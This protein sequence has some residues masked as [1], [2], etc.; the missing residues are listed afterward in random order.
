MSIV[1]P[2]NDDNIHTG[3]KATTDAIRIKEA[4]SQVANLTPITGMLV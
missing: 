4:R 3:S 1:V 2:T